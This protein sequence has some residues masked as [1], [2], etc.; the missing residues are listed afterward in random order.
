MKILHE[1]QIQHKI[2]RMAIEIYE[3]HAEESHVYLAGINSN[4]MRLAS[5]LNKELQ[6]LSPLV[7]H[8]C[9]ISLNPAKPLD[10]EVSLD[11]D[12]LKLKNKVIVIVDDV[13]NTGRTIFFSYKPFM[14]IIPKKIEVAVLIDRM[15]K[16]YP[17]LVDYVGL[18]L[19]TTVKDN[20]KVNL[21]DQNPWFVEME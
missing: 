8:V 19:A 12:S 1:K 10:T 9:H 5:L 2:K 16:S 20:I 17:V 11:I 7:S 21:N 4:G 13:A 6:A 15:H 18:R 14:T 3:R